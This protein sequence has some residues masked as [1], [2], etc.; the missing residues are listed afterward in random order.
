MWMPSLT[1]FRENSS[2]SREFKP[3]LA[4]KMLQAGYEQVGIQSV[5]GV[6]Y[7]KLLNFMQFF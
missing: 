3:V 5:L 2:D 6:I 4:L 1:E 7:R